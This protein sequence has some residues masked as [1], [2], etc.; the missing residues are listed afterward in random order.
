MIKKFL[1]I[2]AFYNI[3]FVQATSLRPS[4][5]IFEQINWG[6]STRCTVSSFN[7]CSCQEQRDQMDPCDGKV[8]PARDCKH[9]P[10]LFTGM[11]ALLGQ[12]LH[13]PNALSWLEFMTMCFGS[14]HWSSPWCW[15]CF[16]STQAV[17]ETHPWHNYLWMWDI[18]CN[19]QA[20]Y[21]VTT[22]G[23]TC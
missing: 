21:W 14:S 23:P 4:T 1:S 19:M 7:V 17:N 13:T 22:S 11:F 20:V 8:L 18:P 16:V 3:T 12:H 6:L 5:E 9:H 2:E 10:F 15:W